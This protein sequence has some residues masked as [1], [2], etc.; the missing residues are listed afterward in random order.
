MSGGHFDYEQYKISMIADIVE[1]L[2]V[3]NEDETLDEWGTRRGYFFRK[4][5][6][7]E[8][9]RG[10]DLLRKAAVYA[11][12]IDWLVSGDDGEDSFLERLKEDLKEDDERRRKR[13]L[14]PG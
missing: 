1:E 2:I 14:D 11:Q 8:F 6:I 3:S 10:L 5:V 7:D 12:R 13:E 4:E 9:K